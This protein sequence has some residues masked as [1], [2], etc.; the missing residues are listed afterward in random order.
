MTSADLEETVRNEDF[1]T[2]YPHSEDDLAWENKSLIIFIAQ[3]AQ[4]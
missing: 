1:S 2:L 3:K 4:F